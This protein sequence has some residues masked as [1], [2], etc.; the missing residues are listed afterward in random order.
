M[1]IILIAVVLFKL[2]DV[3]GLCDL[4]GCNLSLSRSTRSLIIYAQ[5]VIKQ[6]NINPIK[7]SMSLD[8]I[9]KFFENNKGAKT[10]R[11]FIHW[12]GLMDKNI[13]RK[14]DIIFQ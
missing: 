3:K 11:F 10:I 4:D 5:P 1:A 6:K 8:R 13:C 9:N 12:F 7:A 14:K 2:P